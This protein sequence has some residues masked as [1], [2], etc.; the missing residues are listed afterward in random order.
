MKFNQDGSSAGD[1]IKGFGMPASVAV[2]GSG[3]VYV[4]DN[5]D[6]SVSVLDQTG[7]VL[8]SLGAGKGEFGMP[9]DIAVAADGSIYVTDSKNNV[10]KVYAADG[11]ALFSFGAAGSG[12]GQF[13]FPAGIAIDST[14]GEVYVVDQRNARVQVFTAA[15]SFQRAFGSFGSGSGQFVRPQGIYVAGGKVFVVDAFHSTIKV[16]DTAGN[17]LGT[18]GQMTDAGGNLKV[19][20]DVTTSG[21]KVIVSNANDGTIKLFELLDPK[22]L[23]VTPSSVSFNTLT[24]VNPAAQTVQVDGQV[25]GTSVAWTASVASPF[26]PITL[27]KTSGSTLSAVTV[28]VDVTGIASGSYTGTVNFTANG[29]NFPLTV[30]LTVQA[31]QQQLFVSPSGINLYYQKDGALSGGNL[32]ITSSNGTLQWTSSANAQWLDVLPASGATPGMLSVALNQNANSLADG[33]YYATVSVASPGAIGSPVAVPVSLKVA[34][35]GSIIVNTNL[36][37]AAFTVSGPSPSIGTGRAWRTD[38]AKPGTYTVQFDY[39][40]GYRKPANRTFELKS[41]KTV[42][43]DARYQPVDVANIIVAA[44]G[45]RESS[46]SLVR[47]VDMAGNPVSEF[48]AFTRRDGG[49]GKYGAVVATAD[50]DGDGTSEIV[51]AQG[52]GEENPAG[53]K[54]FRYD[55]TLLSSVNSLDD[56]RYGANIAVGDILG[57]GQYEVAMSMAAKRSNLQ[58]VVIYQFSGFNLVEK[59]RVSISNTGDYPADIAFGDVNGDGML[60][61]IVSVQ[62]GISIYSFDQT[63]APTLVNSGAVT[64][65]GGKGASSKAQMTV[66][67]G[68]VAGDGIDDIILGYGD[69]TDSYV[70]FFDSSLTSQGAALKAFAR[71]KSAPTLSSMDM[72]GDGTAEILAG[73]GEGNNSDSTVRVYDASGT[74]LKEI[75]VF[76]SA[77]KSGVN[78]VFG[79]KK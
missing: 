32:S 27:D 7:T 39:V 50:I 3:R 59:A 37:G 66:A 26:F 6:G 14:N 52:A 18:I 10:V 44:K 65:S 38:E 53:L 2:D 72:S 41:G 60:E 40:S 24:G 70:E 16:F 57:D 8:F 34:T 62:G 67:A 78:A 77:V 46:N 79:V 68:N 55:G 5:R 43:I 20:I 45:P 19:P 69:G 1:D 61:L 73:K 30:G 15:G 56:T 48:K 17:A 42:T 75:K 71:T 47:V 31:P 25:A 63:L 22:G 12:N 21:T 28:S 11:T 76:D 13:S 58:A 49:S 36:D 35:A 4:G 23:I 51:V 33:T 9:G 74:M 54:V 29:V 64:V